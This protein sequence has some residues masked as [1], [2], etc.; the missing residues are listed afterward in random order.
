VALDFVVQEGPKA[1]E[2]DPGNGHLLASVLQFLQIQASSSPERLASLA[3]LLEQLQSLA[4]NRLY[5]HHRLASQALLKGDY[6]GTLRIIGAFE[7]V[8]PGTS[9]GFQGLRRA[10]EEGMRSGK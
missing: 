8:A 1:L 10:A 5:T 9:F 7:A 3:P 4:P 6:E 2:A